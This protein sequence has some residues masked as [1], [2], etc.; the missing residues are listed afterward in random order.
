MR[1]LKSEVLNPSGDDDWNRGYERGFS[2][3]VAEM[4]GITGRLKTG[5][6]PSDLRMEN[7]KLKKLVATLLGPIAKAV[8]DA[9]KELENPGLSL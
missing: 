9:R 6:M 1:K 7:E 8:G 2:A 5:K 3:S 4:T